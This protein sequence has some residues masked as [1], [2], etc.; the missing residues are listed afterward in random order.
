MLSI[1]N[2][3]KNTTSKFQEISEQAP[4]ATPP[5][6]RKSPTPPPPPKIIEVPTPIPKEPETL[7]QIELKLPKRPVRERLGA[8]EDLKKVL[9]KEKEVEKRI[10]SPERLNSKVI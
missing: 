9:E 5:L 3:T 6:N 4:V 2:H 1:L 8:R 7:P 10:E